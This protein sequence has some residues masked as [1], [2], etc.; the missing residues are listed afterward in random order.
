MKSLSSDDLALFVLVARAGSFSRAALHAGS[1]QSTIS[2]HIAL[3]E[4]GLGV[5]LFQRSG[6]GVILTDRGLELQQYAET[7]ART[8]ESAS[9]AMSARAD[10][11]PVR[12]RIAA[13]PTIAR[14]VFGALGHALHSR[15][16]GTRIRFVESLANQL[17]G[18]LHDGEIDIAMLYLPEQ[19]G[20][21]TYDPLVH[22]GMHL[23]A[24]PGYPVRGDHFPVGRL[25][26]VPLIMPST[27]HG[28][29]MLVEALAARHEFEPKI[30][31]EC[32]G[33]ISITKLLV[34]QGCGCTLLPVAAVND[35]IRAGRLVSWP[36]GK[37]EVS[38]TV[39]IVTGKASAAT[40]G[41]WQTI[42]I[43]KSLVANLV[44]QQRWPGAVLVPAMAQV[45]PAAGAGL[46]EPT[47]APAA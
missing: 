30:A 42:S 32:D 35:D 43:I 23:V 47:A 38:R 25:G 15:F 9:Q 22:E 11:G 6:R 16:P 34:M 18:S 44:Q 7:V 12:L 3:L 40:A 5:R 26:E 27:H 21:L 19:P 17:L 20:T 8:L 33:S 46:S 4:S 24:P 1:N 45:N 37:P 29:R 28:I 2:R 10:N 41:L 36:L 39:G 14:V 31:L 13:Q